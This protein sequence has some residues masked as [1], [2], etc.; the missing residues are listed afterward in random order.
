MGPE[1]VTPTPETVHF[2]QQLRDPKNRRKF[3]HTLLFYFAFTALGICRAQHGP[4]FLDLAQVTGSNVEE[5]SV[6]YT[7]R[8][9]GGLV[10]SVIMGVL[11]EKFPKHRKTLVASLCLLS[12]VSV[13]IIPWSKDYILTICLFGVNGILT[14]AFDS[15]GNVE[16][17]S[18]WGVEGKIY[19][20]ILHFLFTIGTTLAPVIVEPFLSERKTLN[21]T[22]CDAY[23][24]LQSLKFSDRADANNSTEKYVLLP[25]SCVFSENQIQYAYMIGAVLSFLSGIMITA[26][27]FFSPPDT[28]GE[29][30]N[31]NN[32]NP[33]VLPQWLQ[34]LILGNIGL[35]YFFNCSTISVIV[36]YMMA[37]F[38]K[39]LGWSKEKT[40]IFASITYAGFAISRLLC[41]ILD[42]VLT[43]RQLLY[44][45][46]GLCVCS[47][48]GLW[49]SVI[50]ESDAGIWICMVL[51][52][53]GMSAIFPTGLVYIENDVMK[54][55]GMVTSV[56]WVAG[57]LQGIV[58]PLLVGYLF[59]TISYKWYIYLAFIEAILAFVFFLSTVLIVRRLVEKYGS[60]ESKNTFDG[61]NMEETFIEENERTKNVETCQNGQTENKQES[62]DVPKESDHFSL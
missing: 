7:S 37:Y 46:N 59:Q 44:I 39:D 8:A 40:A 24:V 60:L 45:S 29:T 12:A 35:F 49:L 55:S 32:R 14:A 61:K 15:G 48:G 43:P 38:V 19:I 34:V 51:A 50:H 36:G 47:L 62:K 17:M 42:R 21:G 31:E 57:N 33:R 58:N 1:S 16:M 18:T 6:F 4:A 13:S 30:R 53:I 25:E 52:S 11:L 28:K 5:A 23:E 3:I 41:V 2:R 10:G 27:C 22:L 20:Q 56:I 54:V 9:V 26:E